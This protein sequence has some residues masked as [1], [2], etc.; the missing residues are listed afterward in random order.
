VSVEARHAALIRDLI[1]DG[2]FAASDVIDINGLDTSRTPS[3]VLALAAKYI[4]TKINADDLPT[5]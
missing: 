2:S 3:E 1:S 5:L 4:K